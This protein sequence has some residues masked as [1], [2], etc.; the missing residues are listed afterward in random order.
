MRRPRGRPLLPLDAVALE[1]PLEHSLA[2][3]EAVCAQHPLQR[4]D[5][6]VRLL[7]HKAENRVPLRFGPPG[8]EVA[9]ERSRPHMGPCSHSNL[10]Q[11]EMVL[12][13]TSNSRAASRKVIPLR[14]AA[15]ARTRNSTGSTFG[16]SA[17]PLSP[18]VSQWN[19]KRICASYHRTP[20]R[21]S[22]PAKRTRRR[23]RSGQ[24]RSC[25]R[26]HRRGPSGP[27]RPCGRTSARPSRP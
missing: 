23:R 5:S 3:V 26:A 24:R 11:P 7:F 9:T 6:Q 16:I 21:L 1:E 14:I 13:L 27:G 8:T 20:L 12:W 22:V 19:K 10:R 2:E 18:T 25:G 15:R 4:P 17:G